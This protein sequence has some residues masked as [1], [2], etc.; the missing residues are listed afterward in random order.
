MSKMKVL[1]ICE[2]RKQQE[3]LAVAIGFFDGVHLGH[4]QVIGN[5]VKYA[6]ANDFKSVVM[7]F[8]RSPKAETGYLT[9]LDVKLQLFSELGVDYVLVLEFNDVLKQLPADDFIEAY[10]VALGVTFISVGF[11]FKFGHLGIGD[12]HLL[13]SR[14]AFQVA[15][16]E[17]KL[18][19]G[20]KV[21]TTS[22]KESLAM[23]D[24]VAVRNMLGRDFS[25]NGTVV[26]GRQLGRTIGFPTANLQLDE[27][28]F[29]GLRGVFAT[30]VHFNGEVYRGMTNIGFNPT[31]NLQEQ[32]TVE[33]HIFEFEAD[34]YD[35]RLQL[36]F[37]EKIRDEVKFDGLDA[38]VVQLE[39]DKIIAQNVQN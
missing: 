15:I 11:D 29:L 14:D 34:V 10:L 18:M 7:T 33:T 1:T 26:Y 39:K 16:C 23:G 13:Q 6:K 21:S 17:P 8:D 27:Q 37:L 28:Q 32:L 9:P 24:L 12:T 2:L 30:N 35:R 38:L 25:V 3:P 20:E 31:A 36:V 5:A 4:Q 19:D 22:I